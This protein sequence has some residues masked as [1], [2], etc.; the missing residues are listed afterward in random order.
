[1]STHNGD[2]RIFTALLQCHGLD[3]SSSRDAH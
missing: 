3:D 2:Q 1:L